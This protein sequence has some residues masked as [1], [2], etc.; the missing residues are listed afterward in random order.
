MKYIRRVFVSAWMLLG[1]YGYKYVVFLVVLFCLLWFRWYCGFPTWLKRFA[2]WYRSKTVSFLWENR[3]RLFYRSNFLRGHH[4][5]C[6]TLK[7]FKSILK[8]PAT[9]K[10]CLTILDDLLTR[11]L[12]QV[13]LLQLLQF[14]MC[15]V[16]TFSVHTFACLVRQLPIHPSDGQTAVVLHTCISWIYYKLLKCRWLPTE[17]ILTALYHIFN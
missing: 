11:P 13:T 4:R 2:L 15:S 17:N 8:D 14:Y 12:L 1:A 7:Q 10:W 16:L 5:K 9:R 3:R 6:T